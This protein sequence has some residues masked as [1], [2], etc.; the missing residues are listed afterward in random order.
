MVSRC[1]CLSVLCLTSASLCTAQTPLQLRPWLDLKGR[2]MTLRDSPTGTVLKYDSEGRLKTVTILGSWTRD[3]RIKIEKAVADHGKLH[4]QAHRY[5]V[6]FDAGHGTVQKQRD[7]QEP[8][9]LE[10]DLPES[11]DPS[12]IN[13]LID[14][15]FVSDSELSGTLPEYWRSYFGNKDEVLFFRATNGGGT[16]PPNDYKPQ[17]T[18]KPILRMS[19][20]P[21]ERLLISRPKPG[22]SEI[23]RRNRISG[24][25]VFDVHVDR[26]GHVADLAVV[27]PL[28]AG[29]DD[30]AAEAISNSIYRPALVNGEPLEFR[31]Y[32]HVRFTIR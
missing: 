25:S 16:A 7:S 32:V 3:G 10:A 27:Q 20:I 18:A 4:I 19:S 28:G 1:F 17:T 5:L 8:L 21:A 30:E 26:T 14:R 31:T 29:L 9:V 24:M 15:I 22:Y 13:R 11:S 23:A 2:V 6:Y 12:S